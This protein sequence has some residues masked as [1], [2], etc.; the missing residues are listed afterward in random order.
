MV[1]RGGHYNAALARLAEIN[2]SDL[3]TTLRTLVERAADTLRVGRVSYWE[4]QPDKASIRCRV[5]YERDAR[6]FSEGAELFARDFPAYFRALLESRAIVADYAWTDPRTSEFVDTY[7]KLHDIRSMLDIPV[8]HNGLLV[9]VLCHEQT[10]T[11]RTWSWD[12][13]TFAVGIANMISVALESRDRRHAQQGYELLSQ[14]TNDVI[15]DWDIK[16][17]VVEWNAAVTTIFNYRP[18]DI[19]TTSSWWIDRVY[20]EDR[21]RVARKFDELVS[22][23]ATTWQDQYRWMRADGSVATVLDRGYLVRAAD[24]TAA[25]MVGSMVDITE[26]VEMHARLALTERM[27]SLGTLAAGVAHEINNPLTYI[28]T[29]VTLAQEALRDG[30]T[31]HSLADLLR[32]IDEGAQRIRR[33]VR[34]LQWFAR[35]REDDVQDVEVAS[36]IESSVSMVSNQIRHRAQLSIELSSTPRVRMNKARLGQVVVNLLTNAAHAIKE[37]NAAAHCVSVRTRTATNG[38]AVIEVRDTGSGIAPD[39]RARMFEPF[40]TTKP[41]GFGMGL[42]LSIIHSIV[43]AAGGHIHVESLPDH[44]TTFTIQL[45]AAP[46]VKQR[47]VVHDDVPTR[48][49]RVLVVD[50]EPLIA[51][52]IRRMLRGMHDVECV[53]SGEAALAR[54]RAGEHFDVVLCD[55]MMPVVSG[56]EL[57]EQVRSMSSPLAER[58]IFITGGAFTAESSEF[59]ASCPRPLLEKPLDKAQLLRAIASVAS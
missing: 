47:P 37:G 58:F 56:R 26:R 17:D 14:A 7:F 22:G 42:G 8:W 35:P 21:A 25:R 59:A 4:L 28:M 13:Q 24:G 39:V 45:P 19:G 52:A 6:V 40:F 46:D 2:K 34:D 51:R 12:E 3:A 23:T 16:R 49:V 9:G 11:T 18:E 33:V 44:G 1:E 48:P 43:T 30:K 20:E 27:A 54:L 41:V 29:N 57:Y 55:L 10:G 32:E 38:D 36:V 53:E 31:E 5:L 15:W 50:D